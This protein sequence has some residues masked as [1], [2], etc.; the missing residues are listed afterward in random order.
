MEMKCDRQSDSPTLKPHA[1]VAVTNPQVRAL[2]GCSTEINLLLPYS[3]FPHTHNRSGDTTGGEV[4][5]GRSPA[6]DVLRFLSTCYNS[7]ST[8]TIACTNRKVLQRSPTSSAM[9]STATS[10]QVGHRFTH[11]SFSYEKRNRAGNRL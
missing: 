1:P 10:R 3:A 5:R 6:H 11:I 7:C 4:P 9:K 8:S 2:H